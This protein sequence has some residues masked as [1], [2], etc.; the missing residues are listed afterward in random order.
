MIN[1]PDW[2]SGFGGVTFQDNYY[3]LSPDDS[4]R[5]LMLISRAYGIAPD[6]ADRLQYIRNTG[7][8]LKKS[9]TYGY[10]I[11]PVIGPNGWTSRDEYDK[12]AE[13]LGKYREQVIGLLRGLGK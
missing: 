5:W 4:E 9:D 3:E 10:R 6:L 7:A 11:E 8:V 2:C 1:R 13:C 12:E